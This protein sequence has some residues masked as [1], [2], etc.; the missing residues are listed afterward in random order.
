MTD[1]LN[2]FG[3]EYSLNKEQLD[4]YGTEFDNGLTSV[5]N[6]QLYNQLQQE[7]D[8]NQEGGFKP[9]VTPTITTAAPIQSVARVQNNYDQGFWADV[10]DELGLWWHGLAL[11]DNEFT[12]EYLFGQ[13]QWWQQP[14]DKTFNPYKEDQ[15]YEKYR[16]LWKDV[17]TREHFEFLKSKIDEHL[18]ARSRLDMTERQF[19]PAIVAGFTDPINFIALPVT[20]GL[21]LAK[22][23]IKG[24]TV[25][26]GA[27]AGTEL[28]R[29]PLDPTASE[30][31]TAFYIGSSFLLGGGITAAINRGSYRGTIKEIEQSKVL[32]DISTPEVASSKIHMAETRERGQATFDPE[33][34]GNGL[35]FNPK[36][37]E[38]NIQLEETNLTQRLSRYKAPKDIDTTIELKNTFEEMYDVFKDTNIGLKEKTHFALGERVPKSKQVFQAISTKPDRIAAGLKTIKGIDAFIKKLKEKNLIK[39]VTEF[40]RNE[41][42]QA[43]IT[44]FDLK[45]LNLR[46]RGA[47][48]NYKRIIKELTSDLTKLRTQLDNLDSP[49]KLRKLQSL[50]DAMALTPQA[51]YMNKLIDSMKSDASPENFAKQFDLIERIKAVVVPAIRNKDKELET[52]LALQNKLQSK[53]KVIQT[54]TLKQIL[55]NVFKGKPSN[56]QDIHTKLL[57]EVAHHE[58]RSQTKQGTTARYIKYNPETKVMLQD[59]AE[60]QKLYMSGKYVKSPK[61]VEDLSPSDFPKFVDYL[62]FRQLKEINRTTRMI[63]DK[64][65][66][67]TRINVVTKSKKRSDGTSVNAWFDGEKININK[68]AILKSFPDKPWTKPKVKGVDALPENQFE[69]PNEWYEFVLKHEQMHTLHKRKKGES[70]PDLENRINQLAL[71]EPDPLYQTSSQYENALNKKTIEELNAKK[72]ADYTEDIPFWVRQV[73]QFQSDYGFVMNL[74]DKLPNIQSMPLIGSIMSRLSGSMGVPTQMQRYGIVAPPSAL[75]KMNT[76]FAYKYREMIETIDEA[77][78]R[79]NGSDKKPSDFVGLNLTKVAIQSKL[80]FR[81]G[82][83]KFAEKTGINKIGDTELNK[84]ANLFT[85]EMV[86]EAIGRAVISKEYRKGIPDELRGAVDAVISYNKYIDDIFKRNNMY[87]SDK[88][89]ISVIE[90][91]KKR[92]AEISKII[93]GNNLR[94]DKISPEGIENLQAIKSKLQAQTEQLPKLQKQYKENQERKAKLFKA[95]KD[96][97]VYADK[98][99]YFYRVWRLDRVI[100]RGDELK[101]ILFDHYSNQ[102]LLEIEIPVVGGK[103]GETTNKLVDTKGYTGIYYYPKEYKKGVKP[104]K[105]F[106]SAKDPRFTQEGAKETF[107]QFVESLKEQGYKPRK[108]TKPSGK[109]IISDAVEKQYQAI[110]REANKQDTMNVGGFGIDNL[111]KYV[112]GRTTLMSRQIDIPNE[113]ILDFIQLDAKAVMNNYRYKVSPAAAIGDTFGDHHLDDALTVLEVEMSAKD[114]GKNM[115]KQDLDDII[116]SIADT[117]DKMLGMYNLQDATSLGKKVANFF[118]DWAS[119]AYM[120]K[121]LISALPDQGKMIMSQGLTRT[122]KKGY[123]QWF[124]D[125]EQHAKAVNYARKHGIAADVAL[126]NTRRRLIEETGAAVYEGG[127]TMLGKLGNFIAEK[128]NNW[129]GPWY[130][131]NGLT[132]WTAYFKEMTGILASDNFL[133]LSIKAAN[134][135]ATQKELEVLYRANIDLETA[136]IIAK[137]P[138]ETTG[139]TTDVKLGAVTKTVDDDDILYMANTDEWVGPGQEG[140][141]QRLRQ[142]VWAETNRSIVTPDVSDTPGVM[143]GSMRIRDPEMRKSLEGDLGE[144][145]GYKADE[146]G[147]KIH[148][149]FLSMPFQFFSWGVA[150][151][152]KVV[153]SGLSG[154][155]ADYMNGVIAMVG[156]GYMADYLKNPRYHE[157]KTTT[158]KIVRAVELSG[159]GG[160]ITDMNFLT[161]QVSGGLFNFPVGLRPMLGIQPRFGQPKAHDA[162]GE[163]VGAGPSIPLDLLYHFTSDDVTYEDT[164]NITRRVLPGSQL[165]WTDSLFKKMYNSTYDT[166]FMK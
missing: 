75:A 8:V 102:K 45:K 156:L 128:F 106:V 12:N 114:L 97:G 137:A 42:K 145:L 40:F 7:F 139:T 66:A 82:K 159:V 37:Y 120:G 150:A 116:T 57:K 151:N 15:G 112:S 31:E 59:T 122:M 14:P 142:A 61:G 33:I 148:N 154:R 10:D 164:R 24:G 125:V 81:K 166:F 19:G 135:K 149:A 28:V 101:K 71:R 41:F 18:A 99:D 80:L 63:K 140:A 115:T 23:F 49:Q 64:L 5:R 36:D 16:H 53:V 78:V 95:Q 67:V 48:S 100:E 108:V 134:G 136:K 68:E 162:L 85:E 3:T 21:S 121:V 157:Y 92:L 88:G 161:E 35:I 111:G 4:P 56:I 39:P 131:L 155:E 20:K 46:D 130:L 44:T 94:K 11:D 70:T 158:E 109:Q 73:S 124:R 123:G 26:S 87:V 138:I 146:R 47:L 152:R 90:M 163:F 84:D 143:S 13:K 144:F 119:L 17:R 103:K 129:Q 160:M 105:V 34:D 27:V 98:E 89:Y 76:E 30:G 86:N 2:I 25:V 50:D 107:D 96:N 91:K 83:N 79:I 77:F 69:T 72:N 55:I 60:L 32:D 29:R 74:K 1:K 9:F 118:K 110:I 117:K 113:K 126:G 165:I 54:P 127:E 22:R 52:Y 58:K 104:E 43:N 93:T 62:E 147:G 141:A 132:L 133:R 65:L 6:E 38:P 153:M 51:R